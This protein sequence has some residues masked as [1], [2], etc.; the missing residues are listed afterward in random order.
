MEDQNNKPKSVN[1][2]LAANTAGSLTQIVAQ[3]ANQLVDRDWE[4]HIAYPV[5]GFW[6]YHKFIVSEQ[7]K[8]SSIQ[9]KYWYQFFRF[10]WYL[11]RKL[12]RKVIIRS[13]GWEGASIYKIYK[14]DA[15]IKLHRFWTTP[16]ASRMPDADVIIVLQN[17]LIPHL[18]FLPPSKGKVIGCIAMDYQDAL[19]YNEG[20]ALAW[21]QQM[22]SIDQQLHV[23]RF[24]LSNGIRISAEALGVSVRRVIPLGV[25]IEEFNNGGREIQKNVPLR[26]MLFCGNPPSIKGQDFGCQVVRQLKQFYTDRQVKFVSVGQVKEEYKKMFNENLGYLYGQEYVRAYKNADI[27]IYPSFS[28]GFPAPPL[29]ALAA[30]CAL[31]TTAVQGV[32]EYC[33]HE[34]NSLMSKPGDAEG[35]IKNVRRLIEDSV[36]RISLSSEGLATAKRYAWSVCA[37]KLVDFMDEIITD[38]GK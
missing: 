27:V 18:L 2:I 9:C 15:H 22:L 19:K 26:V 30:G 32:D 12:L 25:N 36:L 17:Y 24:A 7:S 37:G 13:K 8:S 21:A 4:V 6:N 23:P 34:K 10:W 35:M 14:L 28:D 11:L 38:K 5:F 16:S 3:C 31:A 1:F 33:V 29:E 20:I